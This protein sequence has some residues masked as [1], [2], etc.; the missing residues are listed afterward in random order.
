[1]RQRT[2]DVLPDDDT[3]RA[4]TARS[5]SWRIHRR[6][7]TRARACACR[8]SAWAAW[9]CSRTPAHCAARAQLTPDER[10]AVAVDVERE[11]KRREL[12]GVSRLLRPA[13][14]IARRHAHVSRGSPGS[15]V[16]G[17]FLSQ[18]ATQMHASS[19]QRRAPQHHLHDSPRQCCVRISR[20]DLPAAAC[21]F[22]ICLVGSRHQHRRS[23]RDRSTPPAFRSPVAFVQDP[24]DRS[25]QF[26]VQQ[27]RADPRGAQRRDRRDRFSEP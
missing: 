12:G 2:L 19:D 17:V 10:R 18:P 7:T 3:E 27:A 4:R 24:T 1:M 6:R 22:S 11:L 20:C 15:G 26:V 25:V 23:C 13:E 9:R 16:S 8:C 14:A 5:R 21:A